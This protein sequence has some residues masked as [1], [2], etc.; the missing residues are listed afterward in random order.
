MGWAFLN[1]LDNPEWEER[2]CEP[3][4]AMSVTIR[5]NDIGK[6][7]TELVTLSSATDFEAFPT[8]GA[9]S[10]RWPMPTSEMAAKL[11]A[12]V[13]I[14]AKRHGGTAM[15]VGCSPDL[16][17]RIDVFGDVPPKTLDLMRRIKQ[18]FDPNGIL[19]PGRFV[20]KL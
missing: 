14:I 5:P 19:S 4:L 16:K 7:E 15:V 1:W 10:L 8:I 12:D 17:Q 3:D 11:I 20:G 18:Q 6:V 13:S 2:G 9:I